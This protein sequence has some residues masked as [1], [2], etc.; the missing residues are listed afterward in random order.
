[1]QPDRSHR[2]VSGAQ[3]PS[4]LEAANISSLSASQISDPNPGMYQY[5]LVSAA[6]PVLCFDVN[7][8]VSMKSHTMQMSVFAQTQNNR[9]ALT[10]LWLPQ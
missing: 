1:V 10:L 4:I 3:V 2:L 7:S 5:Y 9:L 8:S 6:I